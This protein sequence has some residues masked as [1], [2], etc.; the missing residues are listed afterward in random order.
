[1]L[2]LMLIL[3]LVTMLVMKVQFR[4]CFFK[5]PL[6]KWKMSTAGNSQMPGTENHPNRNHTEH[7]PV[8]AIP[9]GD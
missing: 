3:K 4:L 5:W 8:N 9:W 1:M 2:R 7:V 6:L